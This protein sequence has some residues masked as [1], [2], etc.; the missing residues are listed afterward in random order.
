M[1][2]DLTALPPDSFANAMTLLSAMQDPKG[3][4][5]RLKLLDTKIA[6]LRKQEVAL[7]KTEAEFVA[8]KAAFDKREA[9]ISDLELETAKDRA[10]ADGKA[11]RLYEIARDITEEGNRFKREVLNYAGYAEHFNE[12]LQS[13]PDWDALARMVLGQSDVHRDAEPLTPRDDLDGTEA[14]ADLVAGST[15]TRSRNKSRPSAGAR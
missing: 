9:A 4:A 12:R 14:P 1:N 7:E 5:D 10:A 3:F 6:E 11:S 8:R 13:L 2:D 15:L